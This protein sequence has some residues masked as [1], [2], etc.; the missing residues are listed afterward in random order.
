MSK[1]GVPSPAINET[2]QRIL[3]SAV[4]LFADRGFYGTGI[5][6]LAASAG[7][8]TASLYH[9]MG[10]KERLLFQIMHDALQRLVLAASII[11]AQSDDVRVR[12]DRLVR[13]HVVTHALSRDAS[14]VVDNQVGALDPVDR[15]VIVE[16]RD[17]YERFWAHAI[18]DG[19]DAGYFHV[20]DQSS[21]RMAILEMS[22][23]VARWYSA[24][25]KY[26]VDEIADIHVDLAASLLHGGGTRFDR[27]QTEPHLD[28][29][30]LVESIWA[31]RLPERASSP[32]TKAAQAKRVPR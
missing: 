15:L 22:S 3:E 18:R 9:Y 10:T 14:N 6:E 27:P 21:A 11:E 5:R 24:G 25:G 31:I 20:P 1:P 32:G 2:H 30:E 19:V 12:L 28:I 13:M 29:H 4:R 16:Q 7:L 8:S 23:G 26:S 17:A